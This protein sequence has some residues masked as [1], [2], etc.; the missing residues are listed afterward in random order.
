MSEM[1]F[2]RILLDIHVWDFHLS[3]FSAKGFWWPGRKEQ[4]GRIDYYKEFIPFLFSKEQENS[5]QGVFQSSLKEENST[6]VIPSSLL[7]Y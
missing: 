5:I 2:Y 3:I 4:K 7:T 6:L 1:V